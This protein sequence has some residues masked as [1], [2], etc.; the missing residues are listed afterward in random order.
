MVVTNNDA[1]ALH[2]AKKI[3]KAKKQIQM[4]LESDEDGQVADSEANE[5]PQKIPGQKTPQV[6]S[7]KSKAA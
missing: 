3:R 5:V 1:M 4:D 7:N 6:T 2:S